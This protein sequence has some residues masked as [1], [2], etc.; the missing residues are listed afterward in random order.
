MS[1]LILA[2][3]TLCFVLYPAI[4]ALGAMKSQTATKSVL[5]EPLANVGVSYNDVKQCLSQY[6]LST[7][8]DNWSGAV[9]NKLHSVN[10]ILG[11]W[12]SSYTWC[13]NSDIVLWCARI[14]H[15]YLTHSS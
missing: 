4:L 14:G 2:I 3:K 5:E 13:R 11:D 12:Q 15:I 6:I 8:Q 7:W 10:P 1:F 9:T